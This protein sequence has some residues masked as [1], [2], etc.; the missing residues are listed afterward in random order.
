MGLLQAILPA[1]KVALVGIWPKDVARHP[2]VPAVLHKWGSSTDEILGYVGAFEDAGYDIYFT[3]ASYRDDAELTK[4]KGRRQDNVRQVKAVW[5]DIDA[6]EHKKRAEYASVEV[7]LAALVAAVKKSGI[8]SPTHIVG[9]GSGLHVY[10]AL[11]KALHVPEWRELAKGVSDRLSGA[12]LKIDPARTLD[13]ASV[14]RVPGT[15]NSAASLANDRE[16]R[17]QVLRAK[18]VVVVDDL[19]AS[20]HDACSAKSEQAIRSDRVN[21]VLKKLGVTQAMLD[22]S[23]ARGKATFAPIP[24]SDD[25]IRALGRLLKDVP[26]ECPRDDWRLVVWGIKAL[27]WGER[28]YEVARWWSARAKETY[29]TWES[30]LHK[31]WHSD[32]EREGGIGIGSLFHYIE[33]VLGV[34][35]RLHKAGEPPTPPKLTTK[36][37]G[38]GEVTFE[39]PPMPDK[40]FRR[41]DAP[42]VWYLPD[43]DES[44]DDDAREFC[45]YDHDLFVMERIREGDEYQLVLAHY[46]TRDGFQR[47]YLPAVAITDHNDLRKAITKYNVFANG[48]QKGWRLMSRYLIEQA[49]ALTKARKAV[50]RVDSMGWQE[51]GAFV[52]GDQ[53]YG[54][55]GTTTPIIPSQNIDQLSKSVGIS[56]EYGEWKKSAALFEYVGMEPAQLA[57]AMSMGMP[58]Y[59]HTGVTGGVANFYTEASGK[60]KTTALRFAATVWGSPGSGTLQTDFFMSGNATDMS[61]PAHMARCG[62]LPAFVDEITRDNDVRKMQGLREFIRHST[63]GRERARQQSGANAFR[64]QRSGWQNFMMTTANRS[65]E[66]LFG[67]ESMDAERARTLDVPFDNIPHLERDLKLDLHDY[68]HRLREGMSEH[69]GHAGRELA[70]YYMQHED[71][72]Q[73][74]VVERTAWFRK[75][76]AHD[77]DRFIVAM[78]SVAL[79]AAEVSN[80]LDIMRMD[81]ERLEKLCVSLLSRQQTN[82]VE[83]NLKHDNVL[84]EFL[85]YNAMRVLSTKRISE[86]RY[87]V[88]GQLPRDRCVARW[89]TNDNTLFVVKSEFIDFCRDTRI[90]ARRL[91]EML[92]ARK[93]ITEVKQIRLSKGLYDTGY[94]PGRATCFIVNAKRAGLVPDD[95]E[96]EDK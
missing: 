90:D 22:K 67:N 84:D 86:N 37:D 36:V 78:M 61:F 23:S 15:M 50:P 74:A 34:K 69:Y 16:V 30:D 2:Q 46:L 3:T 59:R 79:V 4:F 1:G 38:L 56:G 62:S 82:S 93:I 28:G 60:G 58:L 87:M 33:S 42:G 48:G 8:P 71:E 7:A 11:D 53:M 6:G 49:K 20:L 72:V 27:G 85:R 81:I 24:S 12:G 39:A 19:R 73:R 17:V 9:S 54:S 66:S 55:D 51:N 47:I 65:L 10:W 14:L 68:Y 83:N 96:G 70:V 92:E 5:L 94:N 77:R 18:G 89:D 76:G 75:R 31:L 25:N 13:A 88:L 63:S 44:D 80:L 41:K 40:F 43:E 64:V 57:I 45:V 26:A 52:H 91:V 95:P 29:P 32:Q 21:D 35:P